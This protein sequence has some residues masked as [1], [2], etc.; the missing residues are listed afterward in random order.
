MATCDI[1]ILQCSCVH[2]VARVCGQE[3]ADEGTT[4]NAETEA[5]G[6]A[7]GEGVADVVSV[8]L[9]TDSLRL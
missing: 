7:T 1:G 9:C 2:S 6:R 3:M 8:V 5:Q 4:R